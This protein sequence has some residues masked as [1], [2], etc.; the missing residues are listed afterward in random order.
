M[1]FPRE[2]EI[3]G[4]GDRGQA[5][6]GS[7]VDWYAQA[8]FPQGRFISYAG[9]SSKGTPGAGEHVLLG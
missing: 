2:A 6:K 5:A 8:A 9:M 1:H 4:R 3:R 7:R